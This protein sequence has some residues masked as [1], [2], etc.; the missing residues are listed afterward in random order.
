MPGGS[1][2]ATRQR[3]ESGTTRG[4]AAALAA[5]SRRRIDHL[6]A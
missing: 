4:N 2:P 5:R 3:H 6:E 1:A